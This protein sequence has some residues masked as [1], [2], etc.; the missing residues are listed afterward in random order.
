M[1]LPNQPIAEDTSTYSLYAVLDKNQRTIAGK[2]MYMT[3]KNK[4]A[5]VFQKYLPSW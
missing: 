4:F 1:M 2:P 5:R 3:N